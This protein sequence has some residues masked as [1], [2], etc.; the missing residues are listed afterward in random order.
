M[1]QIAAGPYCVTAVGTPTLTIANGNYITIP[2]KPG[3]NLF[4]D[5]ILWN[6]KFNT[7]APSPGFTDSKFTNNAASVTLLTLYLG[8][9]SAV[10]ASGVANIVFDF[11]VPGGGGLMF[12]PEDTGGALKIV[13][14][15][16]IANVATLTAVVIYHYEKS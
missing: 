8:V 5:K 13:T 4:I 1:G 6:A 7:T 9:P 14:G 10:A 11:T 2:D 16:S 3:Y 12:R 15:A